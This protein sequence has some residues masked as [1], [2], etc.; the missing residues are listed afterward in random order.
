ML[1]K[2]NMFHVELIFYPSYISTFNAFRFFIFIHPL[3]PYIIKYIFIL[4]NQI[5]IASPLSLTLFTVIRL[6]KLLLPH[7]TKKRNNLTIIKT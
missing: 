4:N 3:V 2:G 7:N 5:I 6:Q 1:Q